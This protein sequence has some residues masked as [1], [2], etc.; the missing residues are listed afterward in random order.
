MQSVG[1]VLSSL[2]RAAAVY[3]S[4]ESTPMAS[5]WADKACAALSFQRIPVALTGKSPLSGA[6]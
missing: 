6:M 4:T 5:A 1:G 2:W 3:A